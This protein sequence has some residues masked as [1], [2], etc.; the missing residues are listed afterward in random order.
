MAAQDPEAA[1]KEV[2]E[3]IAVQKRQQEAREDDA[4]KLRGAVE[5][6]CAKANVPLS[7]PADQDS[8]ALISALDAITNECCR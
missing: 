2:V 5:S 4:K 6:A 8:S 1:A 7:V 3:L